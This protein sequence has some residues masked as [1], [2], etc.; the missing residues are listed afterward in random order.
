VRKGATLVLASSP[1]KE[2]PEFSVDGLSG[3]NKSATRKEKRK[4]KAD[5]VES[6]QAPPLKKEAKTPA[7]LR[8]GRLQVPVRYDQIDRR[9]E[10]KRKK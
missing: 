9:N 8:K 5:F 2:I 4:L 1:S 3:L 6:F 7:K 10:D